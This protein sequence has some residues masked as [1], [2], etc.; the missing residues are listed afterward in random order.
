MNGYLCYS[1]KM[2]I[3]LFESLDGD[4]WDR[5]MQPIYVEREGTDMANKLN[6]FMDHQW[7][8]FYTS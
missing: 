5:S 8:G 7:D 4:S 1:D 3:L 2:G 6:A